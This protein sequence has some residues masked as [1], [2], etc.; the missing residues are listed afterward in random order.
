M[1]RKPKLGELE[2]ER[3]L[4]LQEVLQKGK[5]I[6][7]GDLQNWALLTVKLRPNITTKL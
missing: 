5:R 2:K 1:G 7:K 3:F 6:T 4:Y